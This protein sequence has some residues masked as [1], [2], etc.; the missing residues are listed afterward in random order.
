MCHVRKPPHFR[1]DH[2]GA[3]GGLR[4]N[5]GHVLGTKLTWL[6]AL[7]GSLCHPVPHSCG[8]ESPVNKAGNHLLGSLQPPSNPGGRCG[9]VIIPMDK[10]RNWAQGHHRSFLHPTR[11]SLPAYEPIP[12]APLHLPVVCPVGVPKGAP[13]PKAQPGSKLAQLLKRTVGNTH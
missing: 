9:C 6:S 8:R 10:G 4:G 7:R 1:G 3:S 5:V 11:G 12:P 13:S 2:P